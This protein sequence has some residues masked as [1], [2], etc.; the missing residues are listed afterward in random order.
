MDPTGPEAL[1]YV[2]DHLP[3][4]FRGVSFVYQWSNRAGFYGRK[5]KVHIWVWLTEPR[6]D[7]ELRRWAR[8][9]KLVDFQ[10]YKAVQPHYVADP[11][12][13]EGVV[14]PLVGPRTGMILGERD[15]VELRMPDGVAEQV[16]A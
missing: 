3:P 1:A 2:V 14:A 6:T 15:A 5:I 11:I 10:L 7:E 9:T 13:P 16:R 8:T 12:L 4:E